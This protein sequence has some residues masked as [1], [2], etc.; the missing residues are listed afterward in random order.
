M[1]YREWFKRSRSDDGLGEKQE[2][3]GGRCGSGTRG[4]ITNRWWRSSTKGRGQDATG[5]SA[6][7]HVVPFPH[8]LF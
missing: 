4:R 7:K 3:E 2:Q 6:R 5:R 1:R 8:G